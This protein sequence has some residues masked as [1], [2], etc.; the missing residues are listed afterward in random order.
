M[1]IYKKPTEL[2]DKILK[3]L[4][5]NYNKKIHYQYLGKIVYSYPK[6][7]IDKNGKLTF[8]IPLETEHDSEL[9][10]VLS[11]LYNEGLITVDKNY[12]V[13]ITASGFIKIKT[14]SFQSEI[15]EKRV[16]NCLQRIAWIVT[17]L[18]AI[19]ATIFTIY[20]FFCGVT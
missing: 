20:K 7:G 4:C 13:G 3:T 16:N 12:N 14:K 1:K 2:L 11:Y 8:E 9:L 18:V 6:S 10:N 5:N 15:R 17:P 19:I